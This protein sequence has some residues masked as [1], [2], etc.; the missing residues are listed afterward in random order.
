VKVPEMGTVLI[1]LSILLVG[2]WIASVLSRD[3]SKVRKELQNLDQSMEAISKNLQSAENM[4]AARYDA[5]VEALTRVDSFEELGWLNVHYD[6]I[7]QLRCL[8]TSGVPEERIARE[9]M[10]YDESRSRGYRV[11]RNNPKSGKREILRYSPYY[12]ATNKVQIAELRRLQDEAASAHDPPTT[13]F[14]WDPDQ[15]PADTEEREL[16]VFYENEDGDIVEYPS[17]KNTK[18]EY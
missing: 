14:G 2:W 4:T 7:K 10:S 17:G 12:I 18:P 5:I 8:R 13:L 6:A 16:P 9:L 3:S 15:E 11:P 1:V